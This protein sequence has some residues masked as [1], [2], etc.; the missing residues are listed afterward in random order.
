M[1]PDFSGWATKSGLKC[2]DGL[3]IL[4][5][6]FKHNDGQKVPLVW[7]HM[8]NEPSNVLGHVM[9]E[10]Q[11]EGVRAKAFFNDT[12]AASI[13]KKLITH[14]DINALSIFAND[15]QKT[16]DKV[17]HG[18]IREV[19]LVLAGAN[20]GALIDSVNIIHGDSYDEIDDEAIIYTGATLE[21]Q[22]AEGDTVEDK[23]IGD[24][25]DTM[26]EEQQNVL[27]F[28]IGESALDSVS[29]DAV[30]E[31]DE[32]SSDSEDSDQNNESVDDSDNL[33]HDQ[34]GTTMT[35]NIFEQQNKAGDPKLPTLTHAQINS[36][37]EGA[38]AT[39]S[40]KNYLLEH[41]VTY[42]IEN[43]DYLFPDAKT[44]RNTPD[45]IKRRTEWVSGIL[46]GVNKTPFS[47]IKSMSADITLEDARAKGY[48]KGALKKEEFFGL[49]KRVT[50]PQTVYKKQKLDRDDIIDITDFDVVAWLKAEMRLM[51]EEELARAIL[52]GDG[53]DVADPDKIKDPGSLSD[54]AGI[55]SVAK[56]HE[57][58]ATHVEVS[59]EATPLQIEEAI[60]R[61]L[62]NYKGS[63]TPTLYTTQKVIT[64]LLL[65]KDAMGRRYYKTKGELA[66]ALL[67]ENVVA[68][69]VMDEAPT[70]LAIAFNTRDYTIGT[71]AGGQTT[72]FDDFDI[73]YNQYKYLY[74]TRL[75]GA[76]TLPKSAVVFD[77]VA[78]V[79]PVEPVEDPEG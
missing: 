52:I 35:A 44:I 10:D 40:L 63:G 41:A 61:G 73:D 26:N 42:G 25:I 55:R 62:D 27:F 71:T 13:A 76:L 16:E 4:P 43:I 39:G 67:V 50:T 1:E 45:F 32:S 64:D 56:E 37:F 8:R 79:E 12:E 14:G 21:H 28:L 72:F 53:R 19:S 5:H 77:L 38:K 11:P 18:N 9:L 30:D 48:V 24:V 15:L 65:M 36:I 29:H 58:Y 22:T 78:P 66:S 74:E 23:T 6:A 2:S 3:T 68:V 7:Q 60:I 33:Q 75:S 54:G 49:Q 59:E 51:L 46:D 57:F 47:R 70:V 34:E 17:R 31:N 69:E 20:P